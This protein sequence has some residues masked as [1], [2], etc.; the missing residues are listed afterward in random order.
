MNNQPRSDYLIRLQKCLKGSALEAVRG[1]L[2]IPA[3]VPYAIGTLRML[4]GRSEIVHA[5]LQRKLKEEPPIKP[6]N[7]ES[8]IRLALAVQNYCATVMSVG[9]QEYLNDFSLMSDLVAKLPSDLKL[10]WGRYRLA[11][12][13]ANLTTFDKW[14]FGIAMCATMV[15]PYEC[16]STEKDK[17]GGYSKERLLVHDMLGSNDDGKSK[18]HV[19][20]D[21]PCPECC[22]DHGLANCKGF[23]SMSIKSRV[24]LIKS[25]RLCFCCF[26]KHIVRN[27]GVKKLCNLDGCKLLHNVL[28]HYPNTEINS[29]IRNDKEDIS[30][31]TG[32]S[33]TSESTGF[34]HEKSTT[35]ALFRYIPVI[36]HNN[37]RSIDVYALIDEGASCTPMERSLAD[38][39]GLE[40]P[41]EQLCLKWTS[42][43]THG[44]SKS[45]VVSVSV[46][47]GGRPEVKHGL[48]GVRTV[49]NLDLPLQSIDD[50]TLK[51]RQH[52]RTVPISTY[53]DV[54]AQF[55]IG[56]DNIKIRV[57]LEVRQAEDDDL[58]AVR[59]FAMR[60]LDEAMKALFSL[61]SFGVSVP[62]KPLRSKEDE[63]ALKI[64]EA[65]TKYISNESR[66]ETGLLWKYDKINMPD[67]YPMAL[68][69][70]K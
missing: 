30:R 7:L 27:C 5:S 42:D 65:T 46:S 52:L 61:E 58:I 22:C 63:T 13:A 56:L 29:E 41:E 44:E 50:Q 43:V 19:T 47:A 68:K 1:K 23:L 51:E 9:L 45:R 18:A 12:G 49:S 3:M 69:R 31:K 36:L 16:H 59:F 26:G 57:P 4:Y 62:I 10:D 15:A 33:E 53:K 55:I 20:E 17:G 28:L 48:K 6:N 40:G 32:E 25:K 54:R 21:Q 39:L 64:M 24:E 8:V 60:K 70:L 35:K 11:A 67:S 14:L 37:S 2:M 34:F 38:E 66:W